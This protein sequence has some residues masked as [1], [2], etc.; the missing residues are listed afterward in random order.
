[1]KLWHKKATW[2]MAI[3]LVVAIIG[4]TGL[5]KLSERFTDDSWIKDMETEVVQLEE[6]L[7][8]PDLT[9]DERADLEAHKQGLEESIVMNAEWNQPGSRER[10]IVDAYGTM[11]LVT[12]FTIIA[13]A[14]IVASEFSQGTIKMLLSRPVKRWKI[15]TSKYITILLFGLSLTILVY[16]FTIISAFI[17]FPSA[18]GN[19]IIWSG[20]DLAH[21]AVW[22]KSAYMMFLSLINV[23]MISTFAFMVGSVFRSTSLAVGLSIFL[24]FSGTIIVMFL[25][26]FEI[27]KYIFFAHDLT[28]Y[29]LGFKMLDTNTM[30][31][32]V[33]V[34]S[35]YA[36]LFLA[37]SYL[38]FG[39][40]D[41]TA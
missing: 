11:S 34:V 39:K 10:T 38:T 12:L 15:L 28:Q 35:I 25:E 1:M 16:V 2:M 4:L 29:E 8:S 18:E 24:F 27:A 17:F 23:F 6:D 22:G 33:A 3:L 26:R 5:T 31:F 40:R 13:S 37:I 32:S 19:S 20:S 9:D 30:P 21:T 7:E 14:G 36:I 41:V